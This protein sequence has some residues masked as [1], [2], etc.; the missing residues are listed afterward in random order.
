[1]LRTSISTTSLHISVTKKYD[2]K[3]GEFV[4]FLL[5][6]CNNNIVFYNRWFE[7]LDCDVLIVMSEI[8]KSKLPN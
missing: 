8:L 6:L 4:F 5:G 1:M 3:K 7:Q 2:C